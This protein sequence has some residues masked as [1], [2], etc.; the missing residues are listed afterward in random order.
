[1]GRSWRL[2]LLLDTHA[3]VWLLNGSSRLSEPARDAIENAER[4]FVSAAT[5]WE[6][7]T[8]HRIG[9]LEWLFEPID[10]LE[11]MIKSAGLQ[12]L[13]IAFAHAAVSGSLR[14]AHA[15]PFDRMLIAQAIAEDLVLVSNERRFD[16]FGVRRLW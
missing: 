9:K 14:I 5:A 6:I 1:M 3:V 11:D 15:D 16:A 10:R 4:G 2:N 8:K 12:I 13:P 7:T